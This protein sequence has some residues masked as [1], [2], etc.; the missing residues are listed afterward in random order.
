MS[1]SRILLI[2]LLPFLPVKTPLHRKT[3]K[4]VIMEKANSTGLYDHIWSEL[5]PSV[6]VFLASVDLSMLIAPLIMLIIIVYLKIIHTIWS[7]FPTVNCQ[8]S[9]MEFREQSR[10]K[11]EDNSERPVNNESSKVLEQLIQ[12]QREI[13]QDLKLIQSV[14]VNM[15]PILS[16]LQS[17]NVPWTPVPRKEPSCFRCGATGNKFHPAKLC[18]SAIGQKP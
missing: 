9:S 5:I 8:T 12:G 7:R 1:V 11:S 10:K 14:L 6:R 17:R 4:I 3:V 13:N 18:P 16:R 2:V 15:I